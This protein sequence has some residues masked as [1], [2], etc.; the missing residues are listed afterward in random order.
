MSDAE[1]LARIESVKAE[2]RRRLTA[3]PSEVQGTFRE[4][5]YD[6]VF[7]RG[8]AWL[9]ALTRGEPVYHEGMST[10]AENPTT[11]EC[12][13][14][15]LFRV[16]TYYR[17]DG[18]NVS[19]AQLESEAWRARTLVGGAHTIEEI[20]WTPQAAAKELE[21]RV[22]SIYKWESHLLAWVVKQP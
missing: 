8:T 19:I 1:R 4:P 10:D 16:G 21:G 15:T 7:Y 13:G 3:T 22:R 11:V 18:C 12:L 5:R 17:D 9:D 20:G 6:E 14:L 2:V